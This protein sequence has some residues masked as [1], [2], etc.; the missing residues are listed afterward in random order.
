MWTSRRK[1]SGKPATPSRTSKITLCAAAA[2]EMITQ[3]Q[4]VD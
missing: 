2:Q 3:I 4:A 1:V